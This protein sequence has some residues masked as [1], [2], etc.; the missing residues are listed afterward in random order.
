M[1]FRLKYF[2]TLLI[3]IESCTYDKFDRGSL[4]ALP[5]TIFP[6]QYLPVYPGSYWKYLDE[7]N[8]TV[9]YKTDP[10]YK[11]HSFKSS[12]L[13]GKSSNSVYVPFWNDKPIYEY[14]TPD[15]NV[16]PAFQDEYALGK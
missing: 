12:A 7:N 3:L 9:I 8:D 1:N 11:L 14:A 6:K 15:Y 2:W 13:N 4:T 10:A 5:D 16:T